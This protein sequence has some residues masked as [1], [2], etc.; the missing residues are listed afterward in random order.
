GDPNWVAWD[1]TSADLGSV[2]RSNFLPDPDLP[3]GFYAVTTDDYNGV[4]NLNFNRGHMCPSA[5]RNG[6]AA[7]NQI[8]FYMTNIVPQ[9]ADNNQGPWELLESYERQLA[10]AGS[11]L[12]IMSG[13][14]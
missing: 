7:D 2:A 14:S 11:E 9:S 1:L 8:V 12:L 3:A 5:D 6:T 4:G 10:T 13:P